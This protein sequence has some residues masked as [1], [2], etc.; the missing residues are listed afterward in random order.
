MFIRVL[1]WQVLF[2]N[3]VLTFFAVGYIIWCA[4]CYRHR[5][6]GDVSTMPEMRRRSAAGPKYPPDDLENRFLVY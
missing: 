2:L 4:V 6:I 1:R 3:C 5:I